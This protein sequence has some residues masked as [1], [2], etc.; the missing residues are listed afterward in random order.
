ML[1]SAVGLSEGG[2]QLPYLVIRGSCCGPEGFIPMGSAVQIAV[3]RFHS[4]VYMAF[5]CQAA[6][7]Q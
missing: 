2:A 3:R 6:Q 7:S 1:S 4:L 5:L